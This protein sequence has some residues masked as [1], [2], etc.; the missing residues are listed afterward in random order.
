MPWESNGQAGVGRG[1]RR[2]VE[3]RVGAL[4]VPHEDG[5]V[6]PSDHSVLPSGL[7][8][9]A[10]TPAAWPWQSVRWPPQAVLV[11]PRYQDAP[12]PRLDAAVLVMDRAI[13]GTATTLGG[14]VSAQGLVT[15]AGLQPIDTDGTLL[16]GT[17]AHDRPTPKGVTGGRRDRVPSDRLRRPHDVDRDRGQPA[18]PSLRSRP[19]R[20]WRRIVPGARRQARPSRDHLDRR[21]R[22][23]AQ[24][25]R[26]TGGSA[27]VVEP[28][29]RVHARDRRRTPHRFA[30][31]DHSHVTAGASPAPPRSRIAGTV[32]A[33]DRAGEDQ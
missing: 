17:S 9:R 7:K 28:S 13:P 10:F 16:R 11:N 4:Q 32:G 6:V 21:C 2:Q 8:A 19:R 27:R 1:G 26:T 14:T 15:L 24:R 18:E 22:P 30:G 29:R 3:E 25:P 31:P 5:A 23:H 33:S 20:V 12:S